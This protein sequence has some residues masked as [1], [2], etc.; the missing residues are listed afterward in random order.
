[1]T[2]NVAS[3]VQLSYI[4]KRDEAIRMCV[5]DPSLTN[6]AIAEALGVT[7]WS[8]GTWVRSI[9]EHQHADR[10]ATIIKMRLQG[11]TQ[12]EIGEA[13]KISG[14]RVSEIVLSVERAPCMCDAERQQYDLP[15]TG[16]YIIKS[17]EFF[18][19]GRTTNLGHRV[20]VLRRMNPHPVD[21]IKFFECSLRDANHLEK[22]LHRRFA[23]KRMHGEWFKL[24]DFDITELLEM[25][26]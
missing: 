23:E 15:K 6:T 12:R 7:S 21:V 20:Y 14:S 9:R 5:S 10:L 8:V 22:R 11:K 16:V 4:E 26:V 18:K 17:S 2:T 3:S 1:M 24:N 13:V 25:N 19:I